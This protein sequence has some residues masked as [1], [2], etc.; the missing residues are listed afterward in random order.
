MF[1]LVVDYLAAS[2]IILIALALTLPVLASTFLPPPKPR[3]VERASPSL[4]FQGSTVSSDRV[5]RIWIASF[6]ED[7][8]YNIFEETTPAKLPQS[9]FLAVFTGRKAFY[10]GNPPRG[11]EGYI[12]RKGLS[13]EKPNPPYIYVK[14][15]K[16]VEIRNRD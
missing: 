5:L 14:N 1:D 4:S 16:V 6:D 8:N 11:L 13:G 2:L 12:S 15:G 10:V 3:E 7:G 9:S